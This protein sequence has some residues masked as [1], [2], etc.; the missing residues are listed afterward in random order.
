MARGKSLSERRYVR[1]DEV[2]D[3]LIDLFLTH[4]FS[5]WSVA[6]LAAE[7]RCSKTTLYLIADSKEQ[8]VTRTVRAYFQRAA[9]RIDERIARE[10][11]PVEKL[12]AYV[13]AVAAELKPAMPVFYADVAAFDPA[14]EIY[15][16]NTAY[17]TQKVKGLITEGVLA[18]LLRPVAAGFIGAVAA[19]VMVAIQR[20]DI[21][22]V[23]GTDHAQ[24]Y[25]QLADLLLNSLRPPTARV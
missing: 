20:G 3:Q 2:L 9:L 23:T 22:R 1:R 4:G 10:P 21:G 16:A 25:A 6:D 24:A 19:Q 5:Q 8:L 15:E 12:V 18:G 17:A 14:N 11:D 13:S 7:L